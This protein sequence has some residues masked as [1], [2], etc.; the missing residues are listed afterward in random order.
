MDW[1]KAKNI[2]IVAFIFTNIFLI[3]ILVGKSSIE[4]PILSKA[5][6]EKSESLLE[7]YGIKVE[8]D[9]PKTKAQ[10]NTIVVKYE[11]KDE[12]KINRLF[13]DGR[14]ERAEE[15]GLVS[16]EYE[17]QIIKLGKKDIKYSKN[18]DD[19]VY[20]NLNKEEAIKLSKDF[21]TERGYTISDMVLDYVVE[22]DGGYLI[23]YSKLYKDKIVET[24]YTRFFVDSRGVK[25]FDRLWLEIDS[26][27]ENQLDIFPAS[28]AIL[29][30][31]GK[32]DYKG[33]TIVDIS[34]CYYFNSEHNLED[35]REF[36]G[37]AIP[38]WRIK[39]SDGQKFIVD[40]Y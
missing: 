26:E 4:D 23:E 7:G 29:G 35:V 1:S 18:I 38:A 16:L 27:G 12:G 9:I 40:E 22:K 6:V 5:F 15:D 11:N 30:L 39:F 3:Y 17:G 8:T 24:S 13:F 14:G 31:L 10:L 36:T 21:M 28:K 2:M 34:L 19:R 25:T 32:E 33:K 20:E 37:R